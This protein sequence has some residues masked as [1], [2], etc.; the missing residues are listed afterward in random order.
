[1][2]N[3]MRRV[4]LLGAALLATGVLYI[5]LAF[6]TLDWVGCLRSGPW[7][8]LKTITSI[9]R[10]GTWVPYM[11]MPVALTMIWWKVRDVV[12]A[13]LLVRYGAFILACGT[14]HLV[15]F[16]M[17]FS[18]YYWFAAKVEVLT[19]AI[20]IAVMVETI[21]RKG[22]ILDL[23]GS[24]AALARETKRA[25]EAEA[26]AESRA[27]EEARARKAEAE[28]NQMLAATIEEL[29]AAKK[30]EADRASAASERATTAEGRNEV[31]EQLIEE[32]KTKD[33]E[34]KHQA[35]AI[36]AQDDALQTLAMPIV[37]ADDNVIA[38]FIIG[39]MTTERAAVWGEA[40]CSEIRL[41]MA[42]VVIV[43]LTRLDM[44]DSGAADFI[45]KVSRAIEILGASVYLTGTPPHLAQTMA[46][47]GIN[48]GGLPC[49]HTLR[50]GLRA[51]RAKTGSQKHWAAR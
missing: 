9:G 46:W 27:A 22:Q 34:I 23:V 16:I 6:P 18:P 3:A 41:K 37:E 5:W 14:G 38:T 4:E 24:G 49:F 36:R 30:R 15:A 10:L 17:F 29:E 47:A 32:M 40:L 25:K 19:A 12:P 11:V 43:D 1:M 45:G 8:D 44:A 20:S 50:E 26:S 2:K 42:K 33:A 7:N 13:G 31:L 28:A 48:L 21:A 39:S 35:A 51:A